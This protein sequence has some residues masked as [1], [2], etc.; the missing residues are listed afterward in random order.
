MVWW[1]ISRS[2]SGWLFLGMLLV[3]VWWGKQNFAEGKMCLIYIFEKYLITWHTRYLYLE[4]CP[5]FVIK[6]NIRYCRMPNSICSEDDYRPTRPRYPTFL[7]GIGI[8]ANL[9]IGITSICSKSRDSARRTTLFSAQGPSIMLPDSPSR[10][11]LL[12]CAKFQAEL[13]NCMN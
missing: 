8:W 11:K 4:L 3:L 7:E 9:S 2:R 5:M 13:L 12:D 1:V 10:I 6:A